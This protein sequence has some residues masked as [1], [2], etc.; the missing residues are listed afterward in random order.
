VTDRLYYTDPYLRRFEAQVVDTAGNRIYLDRTAFYPSSGG[1]PFDS[2]TVGGCSVLEVV[3]EEDRIAHIMDGEVPSGVVTCEID[4]ERRFDHMQQHSGQ[5]LLSAVLHDSYDIPTLSFH[6]G[7]ESATIDIQA[8]ALDEIRLDEA[9]D[10]ANAIVFENRAITISF[11]QQSADLA[12]RKASDREGL[13]RIV[14]IGNID[15]SACGGT[16]V[17]STGEIGPVQIRK[18]EKIRG[19]VR[20][21][22]LCGWRAIRRS[23][24]EY[25]AL[26]ESA[27]LFSSRLDEVPTMVKAQIEKA[28][29]FEKSHKKLAIELAQYRGKELYA[30]TAPDAGGYRRVEQ[31]LP[32][33]DDA[34][35]IALAFTAGERAVYLGVS[36]DPPAFLLAASKDAGIHAGEIVKAAVTKHGG[37]GGGSVMLAQGSVPARELLD[38]ALAEIQRAI[39]AER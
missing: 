37:R 38:P 17:R 29:E 7:E 10:R 32:L 6:L 16:H 26:A 39:R 12:L 11:E 31:R 22:F 8:S 36:E 33:G 1:Q 18:L 3:D 13:L 4:W 19:N 21:E 2:G 15:R 27:K 34:R 23:R 20:I 9:Q 25:R 28:Q 35:T 5:H 30:A 14:S 24:S